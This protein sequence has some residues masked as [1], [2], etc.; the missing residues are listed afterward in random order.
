MAARDD[1]L[2]AFNA[3]IDRLNQGETVEAVTEAYPAFANRLRPM[4]ETGLLFTR[5]RYPGTEVAAAEAA[6][7]ALIRQT[8][9]QVFRPGF[10][11]AGWGVLLVL[12]MGGGL[13]LAAGLGGGWGWD[14][15]PALMVA[16]TG[17]LP[18]TASPVTTS[19]LQATP[20][21][22]P[23]TST[24]PATPTVATDPAPAI[25][26][27]GPVAAIDGRFI[28]VYD[29]RF[30]LSPADPV[31]SAIRLGDTV[32]IEGVIAGDTIQVITLTFENVVVVVGDGQAWRGDDCASPPPAWARA[33]ADTW[34]SRCARPLPSG[35][36]QDDDDDDDD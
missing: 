5:A 9:R 7:E 31:L 34:Y 12:I 35:G 16:E 6:G 21:V 32:R 27:H 28:T 10:G 22:A 20:T 29:F 1:I 14:A 23:T 30:S 33:A 13:I 8:V 18:P 26:I 3:C 4:L 25:V 11:P 24:P 17:T 19:T 36:S 15:Q 2:E